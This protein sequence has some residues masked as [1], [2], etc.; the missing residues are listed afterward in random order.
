MTV[1]FKITGSVFGVKMYNTAADKSNFTVTVH[2]ENI[3]CQS[4]TLVVYGNQRANHMSNHNLN[5]NIKHFI[6][7]FKKLIL[8][9]EGADSDVCTYRYTEQELL[10]YVFIRVFGK[11]T[12]IKVCE[13]IFY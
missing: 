8:D 4:S 12:A 9:T 10:L 7:H 13:V 3:N 6:G 2:K 1:T 11:N 5:S